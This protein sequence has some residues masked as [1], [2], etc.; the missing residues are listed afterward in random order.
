VILQRGV[1]LIY[2]IIFSCFIKFEP[3]F[4]GFAKGT[5]IETPQGLIAIEQLQKGSVINGYDHERGIVSTPIEQIYSYSLEHVVAITTDSGVIQASA[6]QLLYNE[7][8]QD[9]IEAQDVTAGTVFIT[10]DFERSQSKAVTLL[11]QPTVFYDIVLAEPHLF[12]ASDSKILAHNFALGVP[13]LASLVESLPG[14]IIASVAITQAYVLFKTIQQARQHIMQ[15]IDNFVHKYKQ[16]SQQKNFNPGNFKV[17]ARYNQNPPLF[18]SIQPNAKLFY[19][20]LTNPLLF[21]PMCTVARVEGNGSV[22]MT[23]LICYIKNN[24]GQLYIGWQELGKTVMPREHQLVQQ[25]ICSEDESQLQR[26]KKIAGSCE[27]QRLIKEHPEK[28]CVTDTIYGSKFGHHAIVS[29]VH[30]QISPSIVL[31]AL[32]QNN[33]V[34]TPHSDYIIFSGKDCSIIGLFNRRTKTITDVGN[35]QR[36]KAIFLM[37]VETVVSEEQAKARQESEEKINEV[38]KGTKPGKKTNGP[39]TQFEKPGDFDDANRDF[40]RMRLRNIKS[41]PNGRMGYLP[42]GRVVNVRNR[43]SAQVPTLEILDPKTMRSKKIRYIKT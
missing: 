15:E 8:Q 10:S 13:V 11:E 3:I 20:I 16:V 23:L 35:S 4:C 5:L 37:K 25:F 2:C 26:L 43:S 29:M 9:F 19:D 18:F 34:T 42:D 1:L 17:P 40:E 31:H 38:L 24:P 6:Q 28:G 39:S 41:I 36:D 7:T 14:T 30:K 32:Y 21:G 12:F 33:C 22:E 27:P